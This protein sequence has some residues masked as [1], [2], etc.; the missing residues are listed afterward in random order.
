MNAAHEGPSL[1][2][3][4]LNLVVALD[5]LTRERSVTRAAREMGVTQ[6]AMSHSLRRL[7]VLLG[8]P[9][10]VR[11]KGGMVLTPRAE[12]LAVPLRSGLTTIRHALASPDAF[13]PKTARRAFTLATPDLFDAVIMPPLLA[14]LEREAPLV[15][16]AARPIELERIP[17]RLETGELDLAIVPHIE[18]QPANEAPDDGGLLRRALFRDQGPA[19]YLRAGHPAL[20][21]RKGARRR[22]GRVAYARLSHVMVS[23]GGTGPGYVDRAL[24]EHG[25]TRRVALRVPSFAAAAAIVAR[26]DLVLTAPTVLDRLTA[27]GRDVVC[28]AAPI[29]L[30]RHR[31]DMM[32]HERFTHDPPHRWFR[33]VLLD[34]GRGE[35][36]SR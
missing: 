21:G 26:S 8:D 7:R 5:A 23:I 18:G 11:G 3:L 32:W 16:L 6:S 25:L 12:A 14:R 34:V 28:V 36:V 19:C 35:V 22:L 31:I 24:A 30:P 9:L 2:G 20:T 13:D 10:L 33:E 4:D 29:R 27:V 17:A 1:A 15:D